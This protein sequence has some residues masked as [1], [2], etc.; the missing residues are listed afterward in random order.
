M[1][2]MAN[3]WAAYQCFCTVSNTITPAFAFEDVKGGLFNGDICMINDSSGPGKE[4]GQVNCRNSWTCCKIWYYD[5]MLCVY[6]HATLEGDDANRTT[7]KW[8]WRWWCCWWRWFTVNEISIA[9][10]NKPDFKSE[11]RSL[12]NNKYGDSSISTN[13][14]C[15][16][17]TKK[18]NLAIPEG[19][20]ICIGNAS[21]QIRHLD[22][23]RQCSDCSTDR[24]DDSS[25][26]RGKLNMEL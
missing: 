24:T 3:S 18:Y 17:W 15:I 12:F 6:L 16:N 2:D 25:L 11:V 8:S 19:C 1:I 23:K 9:R 4:N 20:H 22:G 26:F 21:K 14:S 5:G 13:R 10:R 7:K